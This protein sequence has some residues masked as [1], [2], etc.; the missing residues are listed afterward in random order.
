M[1]S[2][3]ESSLM[4]GGC[5]VLAGMPANVTP[6]PDVDGIFLRIHFP[7]AAARHT[8]PVGAPEAFGFVAAYRAEPFWMRPAVVREAAAVPVETQVLFA[9]LEDRR[10][11]VFVPLIDNDARCSLQGD[12]A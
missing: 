11:A 10:V 12:S 4:D 1:L 8:A 5:T 7:H 2:F 3:F 9:E 6:L